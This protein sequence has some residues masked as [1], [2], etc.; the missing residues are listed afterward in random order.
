[1]NNCFKLN[2]FNQEFKR[3][4][5]YIPEFGSV[6][7]KKKKKIRCVLGSDEPSRSLLCIEGFW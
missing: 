7:L 5:C 1:M 6:A 3:L 2:N 4:T